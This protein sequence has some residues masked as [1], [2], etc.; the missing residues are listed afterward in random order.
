MATAH[1]NADYTVIDQAGMKL[2]HVP[3]S[4]QLP[5][6]DAKTREEATRLCARD[7]LEHHAFFNYMQF[8][9]HL[10]HHLL[11]SFSLGASAQRLQDIYDT[12]KPMQRKSLSPAANVVIT[13]HNYDQHLSQED[14]YPN[15]VDFF[16]RE[17]KTSEGGWRAVVSKYLFEPKVFPLAM[18]GLFHPFIQLGYGMEFES[19]AIIA[20]GLAQA[21]VHKLQFNKTTVFDTPAPAAADDGEGL[22]LMQII[23]KMRN[24]PLINELEQHTEQFT[25]EVRVIAEDIAT[26]HSGKWVVNADAESIKAKY[27]ELLTAIGYMYG[28]ITRP[29]YKPIF[30]FSLMHC[31]TSAYFLPIYFDVLSIDQQARLLRVYNFT[32]LCIYAL[33]GCP[34][35]HATDELSATDTRQG[36]QTLPDGNNNP[37]FPVFE[38]A[39][40]SNDMHVAKVVRTLWRASL[41][42]AFHDQKETSDRY[43]LLPPVNWL[44]IASTTIDTITMSS[45][46]NQEKQHEE[47][48]RGWARGFTAFDG[49]WAEQGEK[50]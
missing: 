4:L 21:C 6:I 13:V 29:G 27:H 31:L 5:G 48:K 19:E 47:G 12:N 23:E 28:A 32:V 36:L 8:H 26:K 35:F 50:A 18:S 1:D 33:K 20:T 37:W 7:Y 40:V 17:I 2:S 44:H 10:I 11:A 24:D 45:F 43:P 49:Y 3:A 39:I 14:Y 38:K 30:E 46:D 22:S 16:R 15:Y 25:G 42:D 9:N 34:E 41:L